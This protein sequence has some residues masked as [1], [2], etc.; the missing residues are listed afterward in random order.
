MNFPDK[1]YNIIY[2]DPAWE[3]NNK[4]TGGSLKSGAANKYTVTTI[5]DMKALP[6]DDIAADDCV[7]VMWWVGAMPQEA[8]D[9]VH[10]WGFT[11]KTMTGFVWEKLTKKEKPFFGMGFWTRAG[12]ECAIIA[13]KGKPKALSHSV[14]SVRRA[15]VGRHSEKPAAFRDDIVELCGDLPRIEL[16]SRKR[17]DGWDSWGDEIEEVTFL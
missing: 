1:K 13:T 12:A 4:K 7:L 8:I 2:A 15:I 10:A 11:M 6:V 5:D 3:F 17:S 14:R 9:L 16:F